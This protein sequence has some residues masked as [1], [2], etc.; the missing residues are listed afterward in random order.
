[1]KPPS[2]FHLT[3]WLEG[4]G[5]GHL[6]PIFE[7]NHITREVLAEL[8]N[9]DL[10]DCGVEALGHRKKLLL[11]IRRLLEN[12]SVGASMP[13]S[14]PDA[15]VSAAAPP[16]AVEATVSPAAQV[17]GPAPALAA[18]LTTPG[19]RKKPAV[20]LRTTEGSPATAPGHPRTIEDVRRLAHQQD[21]YLVRLQRRS[22]VTSV[23]IAVLTIVLIMLVLA[24][25]VLPSLLL[26]T[27]TFVTYETSETE[28][29]ELEARKVPI[30]TDIKPA[31]PASSMARVIAANTTSPMG[32]PVPDLVVTTPSVDFGDSDDFGEG[33]GEG[34]IGGGSGGGISFFGLKKK[35]KSIVFVF[36][37]SGSMVVPPK[38]PKTYQALEDEIV[39]SISSLASDVPFGLVAFSRDADR[40]RSRLVNSTLTER[41]SATNW[42]KG[43]DPSGGVA[44]GRRTYDLKYRGGR[45]SGT[46][47]DLALAMAMKLDPETII[48]VS[49]GEPTDKKGKASKGLNTAI[50]R[51]V[52][53]LQKGR[54]QRV[55]IN[56]VAYMASG[57]KDFMRQLASQNGG[58]FREIRN[59]AAK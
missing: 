56:V 57:G 12:P 5:L 43:M 14:P 26:E 51:Q 30:N 48:F 46:R 31:S 19:S 35:P 55:Q 38:S 41:S 59:G 7:R 53:A 15:A 34:G 42:L 36:D 9:E 29:E 58:E 10:K 54:Q 23:I 3:T 27:P 8:T 40:Y 17:A 11:E 4:I 6:A 33:W 37:I 45:H 18:R 32:V 50:L 13:E 22:V 1:M 28:T 21:A 2:D 49:D 24:L 20:A 16:A 39:K 52:A 47:A 44:G 25:F